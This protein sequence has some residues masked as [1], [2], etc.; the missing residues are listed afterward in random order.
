M[1]RKEVKD[2]A[3]S[4][5]KGRWKNFVLLMFIVSIVEIVV[6]TILFNMNEGV[7]HSILNLCDSILLTPFLGAVLIVY[8]VKLVN[9]D[10]ILPLKE[11]I[12]S[13]RIWINFIKKLFVL[14][15]F[16][17]PAIILSG[18][19]IAVAFMNVYTNF[20]GS[21]LSNYMNYTANYM[22][23]TVVIQ[24]FLGILIITLILATIYNVVISLLLFPVKYIIVDKPEVGI[25]EAVGKGFKIMKGHKWQLFILQLSLIG[26][27][28][29]AILPIIIGSVLIALMGWNMLL[30]APFG[31][32]LLWFY[33]YANTVYRVYYLSILD[34][35]VVIEEKLEL[36]KEV[37]LEEKLDQ[38]K[39]SDLEK[40]ANSEENLNLKKDQ[41]NISVEVEDDDFEI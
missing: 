7:L 30:I 25:W 8:V 10:E 2:L 38:E 31:I 23:Y 41:P 28:I 15:L 24:R 16:T 21:L 12:P 29:L 35:K 27:G 18:I 20:Y 22:D 5:L 19:M 36:D 3:E 37:E 26:W 33:C 34:N 40:E 32:G 13:R 17:L 9:S 11:A 6:T 4:K 1:T 14:I 39:E